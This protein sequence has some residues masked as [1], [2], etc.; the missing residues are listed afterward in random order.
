MIRKT[1]RIF[2]RKMRTWPGSVFTQQHT[3]LVL[4]ETW[5]FLGVIPLYSR[6]NIEK[7]NL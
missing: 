1:Q 3:E 4:R 2:Q 7:T 6:D 5:W